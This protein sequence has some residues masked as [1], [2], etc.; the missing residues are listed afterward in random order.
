MN[1]LI[2]LGRNVTRRAFIAVTAA[3]TLGALTLDT[4]QAQTT[5]A[6]IKRGGVLKVGV[7][8]A[9]VPWG[10]TDA[11]GK[12]TGYDIEFVEM[13]AKDLGVKPEFIP[14]TPANRTAALLTGQVDV[15]AAVVGIFP[16]RQ[17]VVL[18]SRP[19]SD[20]VVTFIAKAGP[21]MKQWAD[22]KGM[23][24]GVPRGTPQDAA[25]TKANPPGVTIQRFD[26]DSTTVQ[27][28]ISSQV[29]AIGVAY[30]QISNIAKVAGPGKYESRLMLQRA[31]NGLAI[32]PGERE[33]LN[34]LNDFIGRKIAN[35]ELA[36]LYKK[37]LVADLPSLPTTGE[38]EAPLP[39]VF[40]K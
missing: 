28:L 13:L 19:Y 25:V 31:F 40:I 6:G 2:T 22:L 11:S 3:L 5:I 10:F 20:I 1:T 26:D 34:Y 23:R 9:Q 38:G 37:W 27:A 17:K 24:V 16:D 8:V 12:L 29:D 30:A 39:V 35:G 36:V 33:W 18:F 21:Q 14:V 15:L 32:R 7:Q 4:T